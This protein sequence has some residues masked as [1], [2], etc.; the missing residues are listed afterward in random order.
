[1]F[2]AQGSGMHKP[3]KNSKRKVASMPS[4]EEAIERWQMARRAFLS[5][6]GREALA[7]LNEASTVLFAAFVGD[8]STQPW[9]SAAYR[10]FRRALIASEPDTRCREHVI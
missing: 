4:I 7:A 5:R 10:G 6:T 8:D 2:V 9:A 1:M 3:E